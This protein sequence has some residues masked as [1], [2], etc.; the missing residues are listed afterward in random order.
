MAPQPPLICYC[1]PRGVSA[2][3]GCLPRGVSTKGCVPYDLSHDAF[4]V[5]CML[6]LHQLRLI[7]SAAA[8]IVLG[9]VTC[10]AYWDTPPP[11]NRMT[12]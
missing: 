3:G 8:Y 10:E 7:T 9:H 6:S 11:V 12:E 4:D 2:Q 1:L 5:T